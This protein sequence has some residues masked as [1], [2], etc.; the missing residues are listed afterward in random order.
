MAV[1]DRTVF[2]LG[3]FR[4]FRGWGGVD[5]ALAP[6]PPVREGLGFRAKNAAEE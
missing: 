6:R 2:L 4:V 1:L 5:V 3:S